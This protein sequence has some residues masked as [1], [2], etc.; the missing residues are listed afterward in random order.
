MQSKPC[1]YDYT[2]PRGSASLHVLWE[3][4]CQGAQNLQIR[5]IGTIGICCSD[6]GFRISPVDLCIIADGANAIVIAV[7]WLARSSFVLNGSA[8]V[9]VH[10]DKE[11]GPA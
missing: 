10:L 6:C 2:P 4:K 7:T 1:G 5:S 8:F 11:S 9:S 3:L